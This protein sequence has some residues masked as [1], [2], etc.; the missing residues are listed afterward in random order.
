MLNKGLKAEYCAVVLDQ[1]K[2]MQIYTNLLV[3][4]VFGRIGLHPKEYFKTL[5]FYLEKGH[6]EFEDCAKLHNITKKME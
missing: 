5:G 3:G 4:F 1:T 6:T 2:S